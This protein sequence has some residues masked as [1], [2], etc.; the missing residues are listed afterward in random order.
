MRDLTRPVTVCPGVFQ[1]GGSN[2]THF[3]D[4]AVFLVDCGGGK[5]FMVDSGAGRSGPALIE[6]IHEVGGVPD[7]VSH[8]ILTH[9]HID[10]A[11]SAAYLKEQLGCKVVAHRDDA[12]ALKSPTHP[13][14]AADL[15]GVEYR[16]VEVD[17]L[18]EEPKEE[19]VVGSVHLDLLHTPGHTPGSISPVA[20]VGTKKVLFGQDIHG[21]FDPAWGSDLDQWQRSMEILL[22]QE[23]D[24]LCEG[25]FGTFHGKNE[26]RSYIQ[27]YLDRYG[28][29][30]QT[31]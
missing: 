17:I 13:A 3:Q 31:H 23:C 9:C 29:T 28:T 1:I 22:D 7:D 8:L 19:M 10:H 25:H 16:P 24:I 12:H 18:L 4:A 5:W 30:S 15:Y 2:I 6:N 26:V 21:P 20:Q 11:G 14:V 27:N